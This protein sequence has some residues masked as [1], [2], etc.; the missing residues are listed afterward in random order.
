MTHLSCGLTY[1]LRRLVSCQSRCYC[2]STQHQ[3]CHVVVNV[4]IGPLDIVQSTNRRETTD[5]TLQIIRTINDWGTTASLS[6]LEDQREEVSVRFTSVQVRRGFYIDQCRRQSFHSFCDMILS[7]G[8][9][10]DY[11][12]L[13][14]M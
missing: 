9:L 12:L 10:M 11:S 7:E 6:N 8:L 1:R 13:K 3:E 5:N 4:A 14:K 2:V